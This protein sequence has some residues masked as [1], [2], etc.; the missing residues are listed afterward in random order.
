MENTNLVWVTDENWLDV[1]G[2]I[3]WRQPETVDNQGNRILMDRS[4]QTAYQISFDLWYETKAYE[5][6]WRRY[7]ERTSSTAILS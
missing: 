1:A 6:P 2:Q 7:I 4:G 5:K 3:D